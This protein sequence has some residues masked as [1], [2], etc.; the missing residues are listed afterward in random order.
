MVTKDTPPITPTPLS[1]LVHELLHEVHKIRHDLERCESLSPGDDVNELLTRLVGLCIKPYSSE[2]TNH[3]LNIEGVDALCASLQAICAEAEGELEKYW[4][5][6]I[7]EACDSQECNASDS[8]TRD[9]LH[10]FPYYTNYV[11]LSRL[12]A[13][14]LSAFLPMPPTAAINIAFI[15]SGPLPLSSIC[16]LDNLPNAKITNIDRDALALNLSRRL[17]EALSISGD[18]MRFVR[19]DVEGTSV[20]TGASESGFE[21]ITWGSLDVVFLAALVGMESSAKFDILAS[22]ARRLKAGTLIVARSARG[23]RSI[24]Y[25]VLELGDDMSKRGLEVL[26]ELHPHTDVVNSVVVLRVCGC[27]T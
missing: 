3:F 26:A 6:R 24:L 4:T 17:A 5:S 14:L 7:L 25:P 1:S 8:P 13:T 23:L 9:L 22:L 20:T 16:L 15:G 11:D 19:D 21:G 10:R 2:F 27:S 12:E 18:K